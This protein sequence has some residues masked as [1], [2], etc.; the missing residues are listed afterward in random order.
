MTILIITTLT[1]IGSRAI[2]LLGALSGLSQE[3]RWADDNIEPRNRVFHVLV[4][5][6]WANFDMGLAN[7]ILHIVCVI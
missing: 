4:V 2:V 5:R 1:E 6:G 3:T 7:L